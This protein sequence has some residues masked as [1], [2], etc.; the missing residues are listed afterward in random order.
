MNKLLTKYGQAK[1]LE[2]RVRVKIAPVVER[3]YIDPASQ[4]GR[5]VAET[6][7]DALRSHSEQFQ[8]R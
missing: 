4:Q 3:Y 7:V 1:T 5:S 2:T 8:W 6:T